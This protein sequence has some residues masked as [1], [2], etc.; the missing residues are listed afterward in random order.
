MADVI[1]ITGLQREVERRAESMGLACHFKHG[2]D[3][4]YITGDTIVM[5]MLPCPFDMDKFRV[6][7]MMY[8]HELGHW[9]NKAAMQLRR[10]YP[11]KLETNLGAVWNIL[12]DELDERAQASKFPGDAKALGEGHAI[13]LAEQLEYLIGV[14]AT[15]GEL[16]DA[17]IKRLAIY[18]LAQSTRDWDGYMTPLVMMM[19]RKFPKDAVALCDTLT[20]EGWYDRIKDNKDAQQ[21]L[22]CAVALVKR[23]FEDEDPEQQL[24]DSQKGDGKGEGEQE[25]KGE[26]KPNAGKTKEGEDTKL[27]VIPWDKLCASKH[28]GDGLSAKASHIDWTGKDGRGTFIPA[29]PDQFTVISIDKG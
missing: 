16:P 5:P 9:Y 23:V 11:V 4:A 8:I 22:D 24:K 25:K 2:I 10:K 6:I 28:D 3:T 7:R 27:S 21:V 20:K 15:K 19:R 13:M 1:D 17:D 12:E 14:I 18:M 26:E 29:S